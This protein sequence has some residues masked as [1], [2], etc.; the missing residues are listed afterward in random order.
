MGNPPELYYEILHV[1]K[2]ASPQ[3]VRAAYK[4]LARQWHPDK[5]PPASRPEA[6]ARFKA[7]TEAYEAL[8]DWQEN[9]AVFAAWDEVRSR[10]A[11]KDSNVGDA[12]PAI[13]RARD[14]KA[15]VA[16]SAGPCTPAWESTKKVYS[17]CSNV[18]GGGRRAFAEFSSYVVRKAPPLECKVECTLEELCNGCKKEVRYTRDVL[19]KNGLITKKEV[20]QT[21]RVK[22]G[23]RKGTAV[24]LEGAGDER[25][26]CL[27][28]DAVF[29]ITEKRHKRFK[30]LGDDLVL[31]AQVPLVTALTGWSL[32]FRL[33]GGDKFRCSFRDEVICPGYVKVVKGGGMPVAGGEKG[34]RGDLRLKFDVVF[35]E[36]LTDEQRKGLA[37]I[38]GGC[39]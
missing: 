12:T 39:A 36:N 5:H 14:E 35:P 3:G 9:R 4:T 18:A 2:D 8:L 29:V 30:R 23:W 17:S 33:L 7:I 15:G 27:T 32:S 11:K 25:P 6:E 21:I 19:T 37:E 38:L 10:A 20:T 24:T 34:A 26:G 16:G 28:G 31:K 22:P 13:A 1:A